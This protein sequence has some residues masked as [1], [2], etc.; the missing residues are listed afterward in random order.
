MTAKIVTTAHWNHCNNGGRDGSLFDGT[1][2]LVLAA[3]EVFVT[4]VI[5]GVLVET[6]AIWLRIGATTLGLDISTTEDDTSRVVVG[7]AA[8]T[9]VVPLSVW[10]EAIVDSVDGVPPVLSVSI[11]LRSI[12]D[13]VSPVSA[14]RKCV[15][16]RATPEHLSSTK[17]LSRGEAHE[18]LE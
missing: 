11:C 13:A 5:E 4:V 3:G 6:T 1:E 15:A 9:S 10:L 2:L 7:L 16:E 14:T 12:P 18:R 8:V 17:G